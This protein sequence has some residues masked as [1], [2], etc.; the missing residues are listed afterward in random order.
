[1]I[2]NEVEKIRLA[3]LIEYN[4]K[5][6]VGWQ[7]QNNGKSVQGEIEQV[8]KILFKIDCPV[9][10]AGRTDA[11]V[12]ALGQVAHIDIPKLN[13]FCDKSN[14]YILTAFNSLLIIRFLIFGVSFANVFEIKNINITKN[15]ILKRYK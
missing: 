8:A 3:L 12:N 13:R 6:L 5:N 9:Q 11:G 2:N 14:I 4:G 7:K 10:G 1:M 15:L